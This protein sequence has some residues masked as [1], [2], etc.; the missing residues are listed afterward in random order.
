MQLV[1]KNDAAAVR[2]KQKRFAAGAAVTA[3]ILMVTG[4]LMYP[5]ILNLLYPRKYEGAVR[6]YSAEYGVDENLVYAVIRTESGFDPGACSDVGARG[7]MQL[8]N[9]TFEW[10]DM[11]MEEEHRSP[12][13][14]FDDMY[15]PETNIKYGTY[16]LYLL[17][18]EYG[19]IPTAVAAYHTGRGNVNSWLENKDYSEDGQRLRTTPSAATNHYIEKVMK[20]YEAYCRETR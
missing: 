15:D 18:D 3:L 2:K 10:V 12:P 4:I 20:A 19:D 9:D 16:L 14:K 8:M 17:I 7:L 11:R 5:Y 6:R 13:A 1:I